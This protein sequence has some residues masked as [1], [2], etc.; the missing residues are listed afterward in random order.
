MVS[1]FPNIRM[2]RV[3]AC[4]GVEKARSPRSKLHL[5]ALMAHRDDLRSLLPIIL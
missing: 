5:V 1:D 3:S 4:N 2:A